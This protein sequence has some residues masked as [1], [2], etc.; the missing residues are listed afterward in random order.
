MNLSKSI[1]FSFCLI[2]SYISGFS[3]NVKFDISE[4][5]TMTVSGTSTLH[6]WTCDVKSFNG[7]VE[8]AE[9]I[10]AEKVFKSGDVIGN[11]KI[12]IPV[13]SIV[14]PRGATMDGKIYKAFNSEVHPN[15]VFELNDNK[16]AGSGGEKFTINAKGKLTMA[17]KSNQ[18]ELSVEGEFLSGNKLKFAG[19]Y[20]MNMVN[21]GM[22]PPSA[23]YGQIVTGEEV[24]IKFE[25][26]VTK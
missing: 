2:F 4:E 11:M 23:M 19:A 18:A 7:N 12:V 16:V 15:I 17:G 26:I 14:S 13:K 10:V 24:E 20:K 21:Y 1:T 9:S 25:L 8:I 22:T 5:T 6:D 3:Q